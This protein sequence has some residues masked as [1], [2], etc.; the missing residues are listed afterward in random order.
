MT[1]FITS[2]IHL[3]R[4]GAMVATATATLVI[5][6]TTVAQA[7]VFGFVV[8]PGFVV[9]GVAPG[10]VA[11]G[12]GGARFAAKGGGGAGFATGGA[13]PQPVAGTSARGGQKLR[14]KY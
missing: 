12:G 11:G 10:F 9:G 7:G 14:V 1:S 2:L 4:R 3:L 13:A 8:G 6:V 5:G